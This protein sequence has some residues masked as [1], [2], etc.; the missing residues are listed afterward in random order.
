MR[1]QDA[2][3]LHLGAQVPVVKGLYG[4]QD[5]KVNLLSGPTVRF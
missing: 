1:S 3:F 5:E 2:L 4:D